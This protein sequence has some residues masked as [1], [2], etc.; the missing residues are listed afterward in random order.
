MSEHI[1]EE[2]VKFRGIET[3]Y[4]DAW[5]NPAQVVPESKAKLLRILGYPIDD[6]EQLEA[7]YLQEVLEY[8]Q[9]L[10]PVVQ[11]VRLGSGLPIELRVA[12]TEANQEF[13]YKIE[14]EQGETIKGQVVA[15]D[16]EL[17]EMHVLDDI[18]YQ[19]YAVP[20]NIELPMGYHTLSLTKKGGRKVLGE[21]RFIVAPQASYIQPPIKAGKKLWGPSVQLYCLR[22]ERN[23]GIGDFS[24]LKYLVANVAN[25]GAD[26]VG[27]NPIHS[28]FP[29][30]PEQAS[31]YGPS[32][33]R[34]LNVVYI[35]VEAIEEYAKSE[36]PALV[37][38]AQFQARLDQLRSNEWVDYTGVTVAKLEALRLVF[39]EFQKI[40]KGRTKRA[41]AFKAFVKNGG[42][43][44][45]AQAAYDALQN[46]F[47]QTQGNAWGWQVW[48]EEFREYHMPA[49][50]QWVKDNQAEVDFYAW[51]QW[52][53]DL[54]LEEVDQVA[55]SSGMAMGLYRDLAVGVSEGSVEIWGNGDLYA[56][57]ASVGAPPD[58]LGPLG[59]KWGLPPMD[60]AKLE[61]QA[62]QP[63]IDLF[64]SNMR[65]CGALR[66]DHAMALLRLWLVPVEDD[67][68]KGAYLYY[69][70]EDLLGIL[71][72][73][74]HRNECLIIGEDLGTVPDGIFE[75]F[76][77]NGIHSYR[78]FMFEQAEDGG[79]ISPSHYPVQAMATITTH[80]MPTLRGLWHCDDLALGK[81]LGLYRDEAVLQSLYADR[82]ESKQK[83]LDSLHGHGLIPDYVSRDVNWVGMDKGL[84]YGMHKHMAAGSS[85]LLSVQLED[86]MEMDKPVNVPG[87][88]DE[89]PN[90]RRKLSKNLSELFA[91]HD[92]QN[93]LREMTELRA[94]VSA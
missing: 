48:P 10:T 38:S 8:W 75:V 25:S 84:N 47:Y 63:M 34:W 50:T 22:S 69:P 71:A 92:V 87:T 26:F 24:D 1:I 16:G 76:Q 9:N 13:T 42:E 64:R 61:E 31:P 6:A 44:L 90:W 18:E 28:L 32:S 85:S 41:T 37:N 56:L 52:I 91:D 72:L 67:A 29:A 70:I 58:V 14:T 51:L 39:A 21:S 80:D 55:K 20:L 19:K 49:V 66:I 74:S 73:E 40:Q 2:L 36:A 7:R 65:S 11:V 12:I 94:K 59:Q 5:G 27:L 54:Q 77:E 62:Y 30:N 81:E 60:P 17:V 89:Y 88:S 79:Y 15:T 86:W 93:L 23:W 4:I 45:A 33:R 82:H 46:H 83:M 57:D 35:D 43:S 78:V 68:S 53:A 3:N